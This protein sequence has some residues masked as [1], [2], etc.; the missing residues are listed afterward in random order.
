M[1]KEPKKPGPKP[2]D[3]GFEINPMALKLRRILYGYTQA[4]LAIPMG[5]SESVVGGWEQPE[6]KRKRVTP[7]SRPSREQAEKLASILLC[8]PEDLGK[9]P[10][11][12]SE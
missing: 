3:P 11:V 8:E 5:V 9:N 12:I 1:K 4:S 6:S 10:M 7:R 2:K